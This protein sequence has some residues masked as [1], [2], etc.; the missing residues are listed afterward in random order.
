MRQSN[1]EQGKDILGGE[2]IT[3]GQSGDC[4]VYSREFIYMWGMARAHNQQ[5]LVTNK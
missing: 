1:E 5:N 3:S 2:S 4:L